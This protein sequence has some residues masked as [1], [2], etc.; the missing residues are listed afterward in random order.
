MIKWLLRMYDKKVDALWEKWQDANTEREE[1]IAFR[2]W[3]NARRRL[4]M[5]KM[6]F[7]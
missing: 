2:R 5:M 3:H 6:Y 7:E 4:N 1:N